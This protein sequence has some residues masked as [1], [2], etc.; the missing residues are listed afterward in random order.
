MISLSYI[1]NYIITLS[2][3]YNI[4]RRFITIIMPDRDRV[5]NT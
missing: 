4:V 5:L 1:T 2:C 3:Y